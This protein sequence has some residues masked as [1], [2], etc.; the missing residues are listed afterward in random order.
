MPLLRVA[1]A[2]SIRRRATAAVFIMFGASVYLLARAGFASGVS[3]VIITTCVLGGLIFRCRLGQALTGASA[4]AHV[5][6]GLLG[7]RYR[8]GHRLRRR[9]LRLRSS[10][11][12]QAIQPQRRRAGPDH[13]QRDV[14]AHG[15]RV[16]LE[17]HLGAGSTFFFS[18]PA[19]PTSKEASCDSA[20]PR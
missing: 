13:R 10:L 8:L 18:L 17:S 7:G 1:K 4:L 11:A 14:Q 12:G 20:R 19:A 2:I 16:W 3:D 15:G 9:S 6:I 5:V